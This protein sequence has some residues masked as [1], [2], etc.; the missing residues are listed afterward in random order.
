MQINDP[1]TVGGEQAMH[2]VTVDVT[3]RDGGRA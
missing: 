1:D 2:F 3:E